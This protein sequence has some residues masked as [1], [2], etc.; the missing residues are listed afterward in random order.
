MRVQISPRAPGLKM[1]DEDGG[2]RME[3]RRYTAHL[4]ARSSIFNSRSSNPVGK[5]IWKSAG[6]KLRRK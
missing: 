2:W 1:E 5:L 6:V 3:D 4:V